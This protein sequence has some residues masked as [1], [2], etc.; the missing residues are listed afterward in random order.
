MGAVLPTPQGVRDWCL[1]M[2]SD[3]GGLSLNE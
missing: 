1:G 2:A 3:Y